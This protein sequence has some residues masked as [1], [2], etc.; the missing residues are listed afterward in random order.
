MKVPDKEKTDGMY[1]YP[2]GNTVNIPPTENN[3][4]LHQE[5]I[6]SNTC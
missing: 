6:S 2:E 1:Q 5:G 4:Y 3:Y